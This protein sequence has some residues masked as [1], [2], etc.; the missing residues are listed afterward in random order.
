MP[1]KESQITA[2][3]EMERKMSTLAIGWIGIFF[4]TPRNPEIGMFSTRRM[5]TI[6]YSRVWPLIWNKISL[7]FQLLKTFCPHLYKWI[8]KFLQYQ[9]FWKTKVCGNHEWTRGAVKFTMDSNWANHHHGKLKIW[10]ELNT[11]CFKLDIIKKGAWQ[12]C[13]YASWSLCLIATL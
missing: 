5:R 6:P 11:E 9:S 4:P 8:R 1:Q 7:S 3:K 13:Q 2:E 10:V 12:V